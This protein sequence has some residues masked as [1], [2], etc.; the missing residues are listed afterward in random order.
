M[1]NY[2]DIKTDYRNRFNRRL[3]LAERRRDLVLFCERRDLEIQPLPEKP[4]WSAIPRSA[5]WRIS[6]SEFASQSGWYGIAGDHPTDIL[7]IHQ[8]SAEPREIMQRFIERWETAADK[9]QRGEPVDTFRIN[10]EAERPAIGELIADRVSRLKLWV[11][12]DPIWTN[13]PGPG[14]SVGLSLAD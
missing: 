11:A 10:Q 9:L 13:Q 14:A 12:H 4:L 8:C 5:I 3:W 7:P 1:A 2:S 6:G